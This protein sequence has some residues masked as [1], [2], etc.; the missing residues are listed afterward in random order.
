MHYTLEE[1]RDRINELDKALMYVILQRFSIIPLVAE[2]KKRDQLPVF[3]PERE[4]RIFERIRQFSDE[5]GVDATFLEAFYSSMITL[6]KKIEDTYLREGHPIL[7]HPDFAA[8]AEELTHIFHGAFDQ[9]TEFNRS[10]DFL[11]QRQQ[12]SFRVDAFS[13][14]LSSMHHM[15]MNKKF[16]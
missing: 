8:R 7:D 3:Q 9:L 2:V 1:L 14:F 16:F 11:K 5:N 15:E 12:D 13:D 6:S 10:M 4:Q